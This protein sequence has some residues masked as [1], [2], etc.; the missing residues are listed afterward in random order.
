MKCDCERIVSLF[1]S[2]FGSDFESQRAP[3]RTWYSLA[4]ISEFRQCPKS[5]YLSIQ[6]NFIFKLLMPI[7]DSKQLKINIFN[8]TNYENFWSDFLVPLPSSFCKAWFLLVTQ[9]QATYAGSVAFCSIVPFVRT[10]DPNT[11]LFLRMKPR[12]PVT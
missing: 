12:H 10:K 1:R 5:V 4:Q 2:P 9:A 3:Q 7:L 8:G 11:R 6:A